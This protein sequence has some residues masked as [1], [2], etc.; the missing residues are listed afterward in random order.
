MLNITP[1]IADRIYTILVDTAGASDESHFRW[2]FCY[3]MTCKFPHPMPYTLQ[4]SIVPPYQPGHNNDHR[5]NHKKDNLIKIYD[6]DPIFLKINEPESWQTE[7]IQKANALIADIL[8]KT[9]KAKVRKE[10]RKCLEHL[11]V[12]VNV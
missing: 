2:S 4:S 8:K 3:N 6:G 7:A 10:K 9:A 1:E 11:G 12:S 5:G